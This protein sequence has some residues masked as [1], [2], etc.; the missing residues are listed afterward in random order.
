MGPAE[1]R[2]GPPGPRR[3][4]GTAPSAERLPGG[5]GCRIANPGATEAHESVARR[6]EISIEGSGS[7]AQDPRRLT[8][9]LPASATSVGIG[10]R[11][12]SQFAE[13]LGVGSELLWCVRLA[14]SEAISN[15]VLHAYRDAA[16]EA[17]SYVDLQ[18]EL[19]GRRLLV[20][21]T[22]SGC[23]ISPRED[24]PGLGVGLSV[25]ARCCDDLRL[26]AKP[27]GSGTVVVMTTN[28]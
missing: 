21:V 13:E 26:D 3:P 6:Q 22:D 23:G 19:D 25:M 17:A 27:D 9:R 24:S 11:A 4:A 14:T 28:I 15:A 12:A 5:V 1:R 8:L 2:L 10:R 18:L 20:T 7:I 16:P